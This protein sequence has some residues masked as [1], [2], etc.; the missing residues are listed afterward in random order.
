M[1]THNICFLWEKK[2][3]YVTGEKMEI[4]FFPDRG[5]NPGRLRDRPTLYLVAI[6]AGLYRKAVQESYIPIPGDILPLQIEIR[7][8]ISRSPRITWNETQ[9]VLCTHVGYLR[10][11][12]NVTGEK[13][14]ITFFPDRGSNPV[15]WTQ[16]PTLYHV[17]IKAGLNSDVVECRTLS[18]ADRV[19][20]PVGKKCY[21]HFFTCYIWR[22]T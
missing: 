2:N 10:W 6:K 11:A 13:M 22:P 8:W 14:E 17:A 1:S 5:S 7:P 16:S 21:F 15:R 12:P 19:R 18:P 4:T 3:I 20:S 9:G